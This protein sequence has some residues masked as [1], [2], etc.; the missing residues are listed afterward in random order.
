MSKL[1]IVAPQPE[2]HNLCPSCVGKVQIIGNGC[3]VKHCPMC[4]GPM[5]FSTRI[6]LRCSNAHGLCQG[7]QGK[8][9]EAPAATPPAE[10]NTGNEGPPSADT[11]AGG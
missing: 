3:L 9:P 1:G 4:E 10:T 2:K 11:P 7:C 5:L 6:C 8:L